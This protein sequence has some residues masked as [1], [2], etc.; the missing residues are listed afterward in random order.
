[1]TNRPM[2]DRLKDL[3]ARFELHARVFHF[4]ALP[5]ASTFEIGADGFHM[6]LVRTGRST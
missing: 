3:L 6:H 4:G 5:G 1:M 2:I